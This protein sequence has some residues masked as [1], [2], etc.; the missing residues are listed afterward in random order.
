MKNRKA[1]IVCL[2]SI[3]LKNCEKKYLLK[4]KP[5][6][7]ILFSR[8]IINIVQAKKLV[9]QIKNC[10]RDPNYPILIDEEGGRVTRLKKIIDTS[11]FTSQYFCKMYKNNRKK[12]F[13]YY[14]LYI[15]SISSI[16]NN[17]GININTVPILDVY[18]KNANKII[19]NRSF[20]SNTKIVS[21]LG[22]YCINFYTKNEIAT[23][24]KH[25]PAMD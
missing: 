19:G 1:I 24:I 6:G 15:N 13:L 4:N 17:I 8:N 20:S 7:V 12:F 9:S 23:V 5:W 22:N 16:L 11:L 2:S 3:T 18:R 14:Q 21:E 25:I 10:F